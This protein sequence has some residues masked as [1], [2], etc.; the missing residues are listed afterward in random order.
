MYSIQSYKGFP[1]TETNGIWK[2]NE[3]H[4]NGNSKKGKEKE[5]KKKNETDQISDLKIK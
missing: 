4:D 1:T 2:K 5:K 3:V